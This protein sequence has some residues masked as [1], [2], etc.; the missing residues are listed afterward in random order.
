MKYFP[1]KTAVL[2]LVLP[3]LLYALALMGLADYLK[4]EYDRKIT[5]R[6]VGEPSQVLEGDRPIEMLVAENISDFLSHDFLAKNAGVAISVEVITRD[7]RLIYP[8]VSEDAVEQA[9][10]QIASHNYEI[11][12]QGM[13]VLVEIRLEHGTWL[14][15][16]ILVLLA[17]IALAVFV[18]VYREASRLA[19]LDRAQDQGKVETLVKDLKEKEEKGK[20]GM[21]RLKKEKKALFERLKNLRTRYTEHRKKSKATEDELFDEIVKLEEQR[22]AYAAL[23][24][25]K[26][27]EIEILRTKLQK[28]ERRKGGGVRRNEFDYLVKRFATLYKQVDMNRKAVS[29]YLGLEDDLQLKA[30]EII[31]LLDRNPEMVTIKRKVFSGK[32][33][34]TTVLEVLFAYNGRLYFRP[35]PNNRAEVLVIGTKKTQTRDMEFLHKL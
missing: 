31:L 14:P 20:K 35:L 21:A 32:K 7:G 16:L 22:D 25:E 24:A 26:E 19:A 9:P 15:N 3:P 12:N 30:E 23:K 18:P 33:N 11:L 13:D 8:A 1:L 29:G 17:A 6:L 5:N 10:D 27:A 4:N 28:I 34:K 2:C